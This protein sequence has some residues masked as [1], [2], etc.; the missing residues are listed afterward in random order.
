MML[1]GCK[2]RDMP[3]ARLEEWA[4]RYV[5]FSDGLGMLSSQ[6]VNKVLRNCRIGKV[7]KKVAA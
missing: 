3:S 7:T 1:F 6:A 4:R 2:K 5:G